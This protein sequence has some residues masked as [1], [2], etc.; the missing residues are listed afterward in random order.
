MHQRYRM[1]DFG[2]YVLN[3]IVN[4]VKSGSNCLRAHLFKTSA[5]FRGEVVKYWSNLPTDSSKK[6]PIN[7]V[8]SGSN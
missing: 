8:K 4:Q 5:F 6:L 1:L 7:Q 3:K 2:T